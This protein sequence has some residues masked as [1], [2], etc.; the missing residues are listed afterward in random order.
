MTDKRPT[1]ADDAHR[2]V[3]RELEQGKQDKPDR[4]GP[5]D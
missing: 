4:S 1:P 5:N 3:L 2:R